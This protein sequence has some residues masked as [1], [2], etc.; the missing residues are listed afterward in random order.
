[1]N[2]AEALAIYESVISQYK[3]SDIQKKVKVVNTFVNNNC[4][5]SEDVSTWKVADYWTTPCELLIHGGDCEDFCIAKYMILRKLGIS[6]DK[7][8]LCYCKLTSGNSECAHMVLKYYGDQILVL[9][10]MVNSLYTQSQ[11][12]DLVEVY[13]FN[14]SFLWV[15]GELRKENPS[16]YISKWNDVVLRTKKEMDW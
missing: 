7:L 12:K 14:K 1:M 8:R 2:T 13:S 15:D 3:N 5:F 6:E 10:N 16:D 4:I 11:R 9:D